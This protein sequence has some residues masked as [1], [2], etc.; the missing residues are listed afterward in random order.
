MAA[1]TKR[2]ATNKRRRSKSPKRAATTPTVKQAIRSKS[3]KGAATTKR[4]ERRSFSQ[5]LPCLAKI[6]ARLSPFEAA[7]SLVAPIAMA[8]L[9]PAYRSWLLWNAGCQLAL[10]LPYAVIPALLTGNMFY[11]DLAWPLGLAILGLNGIVYGSGLWIRRALMG[12]CVFAHGAR[13]F[14]GA[15]VLFYPYS[16][17]EDLPRYRFAKLRYIAEG[18]SPWAWPWKMV[19]DILQQCCANMTVFACPVV[20]ACFDLEEVGAPLSP[21]LSPSMGLSSFEWAGYATW[22]CAIAW[23]SVADGQKILFEVRTRGTPDQHTAVLGHPPFATSSYSLWTLCRHPNYFG[24]WMAWNGLALACL[25]SLSKRTCP[26][27]KL[28]LLVTLFVL[29]RFMY[30]CLLYWTGAEPA[31][32][33]SARKRPLYRLYQERTRV[34]WPVELVPFADHGRMRLWPG[35][36]NVPCG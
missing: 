9:P 35:A 18:G 26:Q 30:D 19:H 5:E 34:F 32:H 17:A 13:M 20:L 3:P 1:C 4:K 21:W 6:G 7:L 8:F 2:D 10:F 14:M 31:E 33:F 12:G 16:K 22:L 29:S 25:P 36:N 11:V 24:E 28:G 23:E 27:T 15:A